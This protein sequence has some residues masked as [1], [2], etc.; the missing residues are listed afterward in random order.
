VVTIKWHKDCKYMGLDYEY[1]LKDLARFHGHLGPYIVLGY[2]MGRFIF[3]NVC[4][5]PFAVKAL[6]FCSGQTPKSCLADGIQLGSGCTFG[7]RNI[8]IEISDDV[9]AEFT[10]SDKVYRLKP[11]P[12]KEIDKENKDYELEIEKMSEEIYYME[13]SELFSCEIVENRKKRIKRECI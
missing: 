11:Y 7:K 4:K 13:N 9:Y 2:K 12:L 1:T 3:E 8:E 6:V 5:N 10:V